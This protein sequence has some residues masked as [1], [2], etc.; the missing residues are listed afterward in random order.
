MGWGAGKVLRLVRVV[1]RGVGA[2]QADAAAGGGVLLLGWCCLVARE[3]WNKLVQGLEWA[4]QFGSG[5]A[6]MQPRRAVTQA[7]QRLGWR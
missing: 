3:V 1:M 2:A 4:R 7:R 5:G 6:G